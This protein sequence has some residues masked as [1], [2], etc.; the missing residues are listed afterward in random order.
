MDDHG[1]RVGAPAFAL[2]ASVLEFGQGERWGHWAV[3]RGA[4]ARAREDRIFDLLPF[5]NGTAL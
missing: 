3:G 1:V 5:G 4:H 2:V